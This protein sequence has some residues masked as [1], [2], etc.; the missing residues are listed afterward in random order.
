MS[1]L[2][3][4]TW[5]GGGTTPPLMSVARALVAAGHDL[6]ILADPC[7]RDEVEATGATFV[8]WT[9]APHRYEGGP[10]G[11]DFIRDWEPEDPAEGL[12]RM[13]DRLAMGPAGL[14]AKDV[15]A[16]IARRRPAAVL[17]EVFLFG[18]LIAAEAERIPSVVLNPTINL[19]P[20]E[21]VP[22]MGFGLLP[23]KTEQE[24]LQHAELAQAGF[25]LWNRGLPA[26]NAAR[27]ENGLAPLHNVFE[28]GQSAAR[29]LVMTSRAFDLLGPLP[30]VVKHVG[31]RI[32][33]PVWSGDWSPPTGEGPLVLVG[34][35]SEYQKQDDLLGRIVEALGTLPVR[36]LV[37]TGMG[38]DPDTIEAAANV[39]VTRAVPHSIAMNEA[40]L[41]VTHCGHGTTLK[42]LAAGAPLVCL[43]MGRDQLD[44]AARVEYRGAGVRLDQTSA[45]EEIASAIRKVLGDPSYRS[46]ARA[47]AATIAEELATDQAVAEI[48]AVID[49]NVGAAV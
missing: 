48:E 10:D 20:A 28:Q 31:P 3:M 1:D 49:E 9:E 5:Y 29:V 35:S 13:I 25:E 44:V 2:L 37:T 47:I 46:A 26:L 18:S 41:V 32:A 43:P 38:V 15:R 33:D 11:D 27:A 34:L 24:R 8:S 16:E 23:A 22:P 45:P 12:F 42:A 40:D 6:R 39:T 14:F 4:T 19:V 21:G 17:T 30:P 7:L 36:G